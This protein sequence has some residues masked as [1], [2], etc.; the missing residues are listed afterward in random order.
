MSSLPCWACRRRKPFA[1]SS[2]VSCV[3]IT[4]LNQGSFRLAAR[5]AKADGIKS[6]LFIPTKCP[7]NIGARS[8]DNR[9]D[10]PYASLKAENALLCSAPMKVRHI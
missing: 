4:V 10:D 2:A 3:H 5:S 9:A 7:L 8:L 6:R 1:C